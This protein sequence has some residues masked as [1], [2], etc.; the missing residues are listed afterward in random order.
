MG[1]GSSIQRT[2]WRKLSLLLTTEESGFRLQRMTSL[3]NQL[4]K[5][6]IPGQPSFQQLTAKKRTPS[7]LFQPE[8]VGDITIDTIFSLGQNGLEELISMD[9]SFVEF[10]NHLFSDSCKGFERTM[11]T[12]EVLEDVDKKL[13]TF[14]RLLSPYFMLKPAHKCLEWLVRV[15]R[16]HCHNVDALMECVL[17]YYQT[18]LFV[19]VVQ[20]I[21]LKDHALSKWVWLQP[22][23]RSGSR[24][25]KLTLTQH[26]LS[27]LSFFVFVCK[28]V[29]ASL[30]ACLR[31]SASNASRPSISLYTST[32][33]DVLETASPV[34][35]D[36]VMRLMPYV[37]KGLKSENSEYKASTYMIVS[38]LA[39][40]V[41]MEDVLVANLVELVC[42][43]RKK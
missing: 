43:V 18:L 4:Q 2:T 7:F 33:L 36:L 25:S 20:L 39:V 11:Q 27:D 42:K 23:K 1:T 38:Q 21:P 30:K 10:E 37:K 19:R 5:L 40:V 22:V 31:S 6:A 13:G 29:P 9:P 35:E 12:K 24:L 8:E 28:C 41:D 16:V 15:F 34:T 17:P 26:C 32:V 3:A 14:L